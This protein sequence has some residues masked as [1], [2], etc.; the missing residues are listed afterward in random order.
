MNTEKDSLRVALISDVFFDGTGP[1]R[2]LARLNEAREQG[3][4]LAIVPELP[5]NDWRPFTRDALDED[6]ESDGGP[7][8]QTMGRAAREAGVALLGGVIL[9]HA[10]QR[11]N[12]AVLFDR[13]GELIHRYAKVHLPNEP[14]YYEPCH[15]EAGDSQAEVIHDLGFPV[16]IQICSDINRPQGTRLL[17]AAGAMAVLNPRANSLREYERWRSV[18]VASAITNAVYVLSVNRPRPEHGVGLGGPSVCV[19]PEG[20]F[21]IETTDPVACATLERASVERGR[22]MYPGYLDVRADIYADAWARIAESKTPAEP[23]RV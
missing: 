14:G 7:R 5:L 4:E 19:S 2:L 21:L 9:S 18:F 17:A 11:R 6:A 20:N 3:A 13:R 8:Q 22:A 10:G 23:P 15:Y 16:G 1:E 12:T